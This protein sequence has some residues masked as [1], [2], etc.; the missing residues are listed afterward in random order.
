M[1][2]LKVF[3]QENCCIT[4]VQQRTVKE[5]VHAARRSMLMPSRL[6]VL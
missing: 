2:V 4:A 6:S 5:R 3:H 1:P